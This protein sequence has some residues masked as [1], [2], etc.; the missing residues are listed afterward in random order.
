MNR[1]KLGFCAV[2]LVTAGVML[3]ACTPGGGG[4]AGQTG[5]GASS[6][7]GGGTAECA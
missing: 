3:T 6:G 5:G 7:S 1:K 4:P 2:S